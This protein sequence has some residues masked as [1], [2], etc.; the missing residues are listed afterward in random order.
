MYLIKSNVSWKKPLT[1][2]FCFEETW[3]EKAQKSSEVKK[4]I[5]IFE[6]RFEKVLD[7]QFRDH[8]HK[9]RICKP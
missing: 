3:F 1:E 6:A 5:L 2:V 7:S 8:I 4:H 9:K